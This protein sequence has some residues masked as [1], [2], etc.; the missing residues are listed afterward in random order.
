VIVALDATP[1]SVSTGGVPRYTAELARALDAEFPEDDYRLISDQPFS[2]P[3]GLRGGRVES[4]RWWS[5]GLPR[6]LA[7]MGADLFH[8]TEFAVPYLPLWP[9]VMTV[10]DLSP[11]K[12]RA[13]QPAAGRVR[14]RAPYLLRLGVATMVI[15][16]CE[17][18]RRECIETFRIAPARVVAV[19]LAASDHFR[20]AARAGAAK[21]YFLYVG[22]IEPRKNVP[23]IVDAWREVHQAH[24][25]ELVIA[26]R[27]RSDGPS[28]RPEPGVR[29]LGETPDADLPGLYSEAL[30]CLYP[31]HYEGFGLPVLEAMQCGAPVFTS[32]DAAI[33]EVSGGAA[34]HLDARDPRA[35][36]DAM[37]VAIER[38]EWVASLR[39]AGLRRAREFSWARTARL[40]RE[41]YDEALRRF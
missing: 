40:T 31:S 8:G 20:P 13:W 21:P 38:P 19:P 29:L 18:I 10:L 1:L 32:H 25:V 23:L 26:G 11:W 14:R 27:V 15:T 16:L 34:V 2:L 24:D 33:R 41:V 37:R 35:W 39:E 4:R 17:A 7:R 5:I 3:P 22:T 6:E 12:Y 28:I 36:A 30:A 9:S